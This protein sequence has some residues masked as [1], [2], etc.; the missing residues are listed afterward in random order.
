MRALL[1]ACCSMIFVVGCKTTEPTYY[2]GAYPD[3]VYNYFKADAASISQQIATLEEVIEQ[4]REKN[5][6]VPPGVHAHLGMLYFEA[7]NSGQGVTNFEQE[8][9]LFPE[10]APYLDF[11]INNMAG[12]KI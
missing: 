3:A 2:Y 12:A 4:A 8:K 7:G 5:K 9:A 10:S 11:L 1:V 6:A